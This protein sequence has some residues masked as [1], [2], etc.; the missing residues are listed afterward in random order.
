MW[1]RLLTVVNLRADCQSASVAVARG[2]RLGRAQLGRLPHYLAWLF[3]NDRVLDPAARG[4]VKHLGDTDYGF[5]ISSIR[6][7]SIALETSA[8]G[9]SVLIVQILA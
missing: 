7:A 1:G 4:M 9:L 6:I 5:F 2:T 8:T 3:A